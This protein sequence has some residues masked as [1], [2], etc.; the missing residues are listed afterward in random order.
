MIKAANDNPKVCSEID[1]RA[2]G[3][4]AVS[5]L[6]AVLTRLL[7]RGRVIGRE[8]VALNPTRADQTPGSFKVRLTGSRA[9]AWADF[10]T[11]DHGGDIISL[12]AYLE[13][14]GQRE[15]ARLLAR[16][17]GMREEGVRHG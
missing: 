11:G 14:I 13:G 8:Y 17:L 5:A 15:A 1:F 10:A 6:P 4:E 2:I 12:V 9:G 7:P 3:D 16:M